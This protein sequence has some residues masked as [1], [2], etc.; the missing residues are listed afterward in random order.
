[1]LDVISAISAALSRLFLWFAGIG[2]IVMTGIIGW[3][4]FARYVLAASPAWAEQASLVLMIWYISFAAAAGVREGFHIRMTAVED[5]AAPRLRHALRLVAHGIV[6][7]IGAALA[8]WGAELVRMTWPHAIP[9][10][11]IPRGAAYLPI[12]IAGVLIVFFALEQALCER[13]G[14]KVEPQWN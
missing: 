13:L 8:V 4:V 14:R 3:Q 6:A 1:M 9:T 12:P 2:L 7:L 10:L 5:L 11:P